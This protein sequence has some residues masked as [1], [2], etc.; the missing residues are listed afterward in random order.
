MT[1]KRMAFIQHK[2]TQA[3]DTQQKN[4]WQNDIYQNDTEMNDIR[5]RDDQTLVKQTFGKPVA[6]LTMTIGYS[7][8][9]SVEC[10]YDKCCG[11]MFAPKVK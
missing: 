4:T 11:V 6:V 7:G 2:N 5:Q 3:N 9:P 8:C 10:R 1:V